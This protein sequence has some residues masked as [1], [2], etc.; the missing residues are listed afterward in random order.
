DVAYLAKHCLHSDTVITLASV[1]APAV[2]PGIWQPPDFAPEAPAMQLD[3]LLT[4]LGVVAPAVEAVVPKGMNKHAGSPEAAGSLSGGA[5][6]GMR[7][8]A[9]APTSPDMPQPPPTISS[10]SGERH[11]I[12]QRRISDILSQ[13]DPDSLFRIDSWLTKYKG[14]EDI[15]YVKVCKKYG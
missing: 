4:A 10:R 12:C 8:A 11:R 9:A 7:P 6:V 15:L 5:E 3:T 1:N 13:Y 2:P 14:S